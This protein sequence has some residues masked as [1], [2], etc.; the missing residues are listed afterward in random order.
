[1]TRMSAA[2]TMQEAHANV[3]A[4]PLGQSAERPLQHVS[5]TRIA[6]PVS[7]TDQNTTNNRL[8][9]LIAFQ[10]AQLTITCRP[11]QEAIQIPTITTQPTPW[12][13]AQ[14]HLFMF[15]L[16]SAN[17]HLLPAPS[18]KITANS[19]ER[20]VTSLWASCSAT[21]KRCALACFPITKPMMSTMRSCVRS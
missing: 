19:T 13:L 5:P 7:N 15:V 8:P 2:E 12:V 18:G 20:A 6:R 4:A 14:L 3:M 11:T 21:A 16:R 10:S 9:S 17:R 1:M